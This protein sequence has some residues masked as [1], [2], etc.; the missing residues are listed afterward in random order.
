[1]AQKSAVEAVK[2]TL[3]TVDKAVASKIVEGIEV[4]GKFLPGF[5]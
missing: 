2:E 5:I 1:V 4:G 3:K